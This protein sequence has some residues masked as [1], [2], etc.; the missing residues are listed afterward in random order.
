MTPAQIQAKIY[1]GYAKGALRLGET[2]TIYRPAGA[3]ANPISA[4]YIVGVTPA[5]FTVHSASG[6]NFDRPS[7]YNKPSYHALLDGTKVLVGDYLVAVGFPGPFFVASTD[8]LVPI[9]AIECGRTLTVSHP[10]LSTSTPGYTPGT[11]AGT[12]GEPGATNE[13]PY[14]TAWPASVL[15][16][17]R[18]VNS[19][20]LPGDVGRGMWNILLPPSAAVGIRSGDIIGD[21]LANRYVIRSAESTALGWRINAEQA[22]T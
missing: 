13:T 15:A 6:F 5:V 9:L 7:D 17:A 12:V 16:G 10:G 11:Y 4:P 18:S 19:G 2:Y 21:D 8:P 20:T 3:T 14:L 1:S 22:E